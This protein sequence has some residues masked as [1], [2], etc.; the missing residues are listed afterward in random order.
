MEVLAILRDREA[1]Q[2][3]LLVVPHVPYGGYAEH[4]YPPQQHQGTG[5]AA[6]PACPC[7]PPWP[8]M[9][10]TMVPMA[11][12]VVVLCTRCDVRVLVVPLVS[13]AVELEQTIFAVRVS[14]FEVSIAKKSS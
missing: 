3:Q 5:R 7:S 2:V 12:L 8:A 4:F 13:G 9:R 10:R 14:A 6:A 1:V 11:D